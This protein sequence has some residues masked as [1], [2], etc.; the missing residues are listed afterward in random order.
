M[1][2]SWSHVC[3]Y[4]RQPFRKIVFYPHATCQ[5]V[6]YRPSVLLLIVN[7]LSIACHP[8][9]FTKFLDDKPVSRQLPLFYKSL[10][11]EEREYLVSLS[12]STMSRQHRRSKSAGDQ[13]DS[14]I[15]SSPGK[16]E[17][18]ASNDIVSEDE[19]S[20]SNR[21][22]VS[23]IR[24]MEECQNAKSLK[25]TTNLK[26]K[27]STLRVTSHRCPIDS[28]TSLDEDEEGEITLEFAAFDSLF[29]IADVDGTEDSEPII[30]WLFAMREHIE[31][32]GSFTIIKVVVIHQVRCH[33]KVAFSFFREMGCR[34]VWT[35]CLHS[36]S[37]LVHQTWN[38]YKGLDHSWNFH[39]LI[40]GSGSSSVFWRVCSESR[41]SALTAPN[42]LFC[43]IGTFKSRCW[44][45]H[46][47]I[48]RS[49]FTFIIWSCSECKFDNANISYLFFLVFYRF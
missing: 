14:V 5:A 17:N 1:R 2:V 4:L 43:I 44:C 41:H 6:K 23:R 48:A 45:I 37:D 24:S 9:Q 22:P 40:G 11:V 21:W 25:P 38:C 13:S 46:G 12:K 32:Q 49:F 15:S 42:W 29:S 16:E 35:R 33:C 8:F 28:E 30:D 39:C 20:D 34:L 3:L 36:R 7:E 31:E 27:M 18:G 26:W 19:E 47:H 10:T